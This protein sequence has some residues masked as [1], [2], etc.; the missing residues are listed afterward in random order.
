MEFKNLVRLLAQ[1]GKTLFI[2]SHILSELGE[3][4]DTMLF[5]DSGKIVHHGSAESLRRGTVRQAAEVMV[6]V[7]LK[8]PPMRWSSGRA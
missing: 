8:A 3:M 7:I 2:S 5:I 1:R 6:D 4:R